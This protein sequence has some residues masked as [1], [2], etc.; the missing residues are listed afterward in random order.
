MYI[1]SSKYEEQIIVPSA[2]ML[3]RIPQKL[4]RSM[5]SRRSIRLLIV[6]KVRNLIQRLIA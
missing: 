2:P 3:S 6:S 4:H 5:V 1:V